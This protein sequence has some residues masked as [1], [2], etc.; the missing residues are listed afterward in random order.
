MPIRLC[1]VSVTFSQSILQPATLAVNRA[2][3]TG[4]GNWLDSTFCVAH[5]LLMI[6]LTQIQCDFAHQV[7]NGR[8]CSG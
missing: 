4:T 7:V 8:L 3:L 5:N 2:R 6:T 1:D